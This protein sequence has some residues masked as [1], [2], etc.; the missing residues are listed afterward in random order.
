MRNKLFRRS[1]LLLFLLIFILSGTVNTFAAQTITYTTNGNAAKYVA[2]SVLVL[3]GKVA[4]NGKAVANTKVTVDIKDTSATPIVIYYGQLKTDSRGYFKTT[5]T[6]PSGVSGA[7]SIG[8]TSL[9]GGSVSASYSLDTSGSLLFTGFTPQGYMAGDAAVTIPAST[10][11]LG[12]VFSGNVNYFNNKSGNL[13]LASLGI[14]ERNQDCITLYEKSS[15]GSFTKIGSSLDM[16]SSDN[17]GGNSIVTGITYLPAISAADQKNE[18]K[19]ILYVVPDSSLKASTTYK[20]VIDKELSANSSATLGSDVSVYF[21]TA[22]SST[23][24]S[25]TGSGT[26]VTSGTASAQET[27]SASNVGKV[28]TGSGTAS[29]SVEAGKAQSILESQSAASL[30]IDLSALRAQGTDQVT[31]SLPANVLALAKSEKKPIILN[32]GDFAM[33]IPAGSLP[34][35]KEIILSAKDTGTPESQSGIPGGVKGLAQFELSAQDS[36]GRDITF[37]DH[38]DMEFD[39]PAGTVNADRLC[40]YYVEDTTGE[41]IYAGGRVVNGKLTFSPEHYSTYVVAESTKTF[42][43]ITNSWAKDSIEAMVARQIS[44]GVSDTQFAPDK[45]ITRAEF[46]AL[47]TRVLGIQDAGQAVNFTDVPEAAWYRSEVSKVAALNIVT[48]DGGKFRPNDKISRQEM[49]VML[50]RAAKYLDANGSAS[51]AITFTDKAGI[52]AWAQDGVAQISGLKIMNGYPDGSFGGTK[53]STRAEATK[54]LKAFMDK[55]EL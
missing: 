36:G 19:D 17:N 40:V 20:I 41:W 14:N 29:L 33:V 10:T 50:S 27:V 55:F 31:V 54:T 5:F 30:A 44:K 51:V 26:K 39:V 32:Y 6:I 37:K 38:L 48:G 45:S 34:V 2:G 12:L 13:D 15:S 43:D 16:V 18:R 49:A 28:S 42:E 4:D 1:A 47:L 11:K 22:S 23:G 25:S 21:T 8:I 3:Y 9:G 52:A 46:A 53:N 7:M 24:S 35:D